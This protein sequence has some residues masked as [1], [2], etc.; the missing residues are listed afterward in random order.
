MPRADD[1]IVERAMEDLEAGIQ[2]KAVL[3]RRSGHPLLARAIEA[4]VNGA[5]ATLQLRSKFRDDVRFVLSLAHRCNAG[6]DPAA[7]ADEHIERALRMKEMSLI[8]REKDPAF[9]PLLHKNRDLLAKRLPD[10]AR[11]AAVPDPADYDDLVRKAFPDRKAAETIV[12]ENHDHVLGLV[13]HVAAHPHLLRVPQSWVPRLRD[14]AVEL[15]E[16][17]TARV[18]KG[19]DEIYSAR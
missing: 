18:M 9:P 3:I 4:G 1:L 5:V 15:L 10:L 7:L 19:I 2:H 16:W 13:E 14:V 8:V 6:E 12:R 11:M 17:Q